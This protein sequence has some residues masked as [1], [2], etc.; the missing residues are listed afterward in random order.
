MGLTDSYHHCPEMHLPGR[1]I[2]SSI[3][4]VVRTLCGLSSK[5]VFATDLPDVNHANR[6]EISPRFV[7]ARPRF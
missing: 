4:T 1:P 3:K 2:S 5:R 6:M 7:E